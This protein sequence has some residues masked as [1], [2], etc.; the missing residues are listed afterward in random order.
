MRTLDPQW[1]RDMGRRLLA[2]S[3][4]ATDARLDF[5]RCGARANPLEPA[6]RG[7]GRFDLSRKGTN[8]VNTNGVTAIFM[9]CLTGVTFRC[10]RQ[11]RVSGWLRPGPSCWSSPVP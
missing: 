11:I 5:E 2:P 9:L 3:V 1:V 10:S 6:V 7:V 8:G 4:R